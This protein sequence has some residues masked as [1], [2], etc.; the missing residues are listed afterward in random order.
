[1]IGYFSLFEILPYT[2]CTSRLMSYQSMFITFIYIYINSL[3]FCESIGR[4]SFKLLDLILN[5]LLLFAESFI[6]C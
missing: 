1:M 3:F 5:Y 2:L 4:N 6:Y